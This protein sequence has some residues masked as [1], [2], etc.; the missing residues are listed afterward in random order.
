M[1][2]SKHESCKM[3]VSVDCSKQLWGRVSAHGWLY[4]RPV[5]ARNGLSCRPICSFSRCLWLT[6][7]RSQDD[8]LVKCCLVFAG[9]FQSTRLSLLCR[10]QPSSAP[11]SAR[12]S[13]HLGQDVW[14]R[15][16]CVF[17]G[18]VGVALFVPIPEVKGQM[19]VGARD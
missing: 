9:P 19:N 1:H 10:G 16:H 14:P 11:G 6:I 12:S 4:R 7:D 18:R 17:P 2:P 3:Y 15:V 5:G 8:K 13:Q